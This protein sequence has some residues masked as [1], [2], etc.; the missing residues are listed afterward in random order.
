ME[1]FMDI[2]VNI[3][4]IAYSIELSAILR[5]LVPKSSFRQIMLKH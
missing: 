3:S 5:F 2:N 4:L 1:N